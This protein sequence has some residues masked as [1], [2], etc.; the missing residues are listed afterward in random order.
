MTSARDIRREAD[1]SRLRRDAARGTGSTR[2]SPPS[3][4]RAQRGGARVARWPGVAG[5]SVAVVVRPDERVSRSSRVPRG[6]AIASSLG[7]TRSSSGGTP[8]RSGPG[9]SDRRTR[10]AAPSC[11][12]ASAASV[13]RAG[14]APRSRSRCAVRRLRAGDGLATGVRRR[15]SRRLLRRS[16]SCRSPR[17]SSPPT[18]SART[19]PRATSRSARR[20]AR[21]SCSLATLPYD[22]D[23]AHER[24]SS[25]SRSRSV[26][27]IVVG[28][29]LR[30]RAAL[31]RALREKAALLERRGE[32]AAGRAVADERTRIAGEL[33]DVV[34]HALSAMTV[35]A[36]G[37]RRLALTRPELAREAF[38]AIES[39][40]REALDELRR[41]LG[42]LRREDAELDARARSRRCATCARSLAAHDRAPGLPVTL[43]VEGEERELPA[44]IDVTAYRVVQDALAA[45]LELGG[46][47]R[48][49]VRLRFCAARGRDRRPRRRPVGD[50]AA[51]DGHPRA[52]R[53]PRRPLRRARARRPAAT[54]S[55]R[56][57]RSTAARCR[58][59]TR[60]APCELAERGDR[61]LRRVGAA[62]RA[63]PAAA[64]R[65]DRAARAAR[66]R[67]STGSSR[68]SSP[69]PALV[70]VLLSP[71]LAG[72]WSPTSR[73]RSATPSRSRWR[74][75]A[76]L[77]RARRD[78][79]GDLDDGPHADAG[80]GPLRAVR[81]R[82]HGR[83]TRAP[84]TATG[85][86]RTPGSC[87]SPPRCPRSSPRWTT[88]RRRLRLP[89]ADRDRRVARRAHRARA[90]A[91]RGRA[92]RDRRAAR[93]GAARTRGALAAVDERRRIAREM[94]D[95]VAHSM[96][97]MV[98][99]A[100]GAR[101][102]LDRDPGRALEAADADRAHRPRGAGRDAPP[103]R[104]ARRHRPAGARSRRSRRSREI[105]ELV[106]R[107][108]AAGPADR[109]RG[110]RRRAAPLPAGLDLAAYRIVQEAL[111]NALKHA[112]HARTD[113]DRRLGRGRRSRSRSATTAR[114]TA[115]RRHRP[116]PR[117]RRACASACGS[118]AA[119]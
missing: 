82:A 55:A 8:C 87:S 105:G 114:G 25:R 81:R 85:G 44:G 109:A 49:E 23:V 84:P 31:N 48:A 43:R 37:A 83:A 56:R 106:A 28:R 94:H 39:A 40:G 113:C 76:P 92:A 1:T 27:P 53:P 47:G 29:L 116:R 96:S 70:E 101:R 66:R 102:I 14:R 4:G 99:Q 110:P 12:R 103:A 98:V 73:S 68:P 2:R 112:G 50:R 51:A 22:E 63:A 58:A 62:S 93:G 108:R 65:A 117:P 71:E 86:R 61:A 52:R 32:D 88:G 45:A 3:N 38:G 115:A 30:S 119:S 10:P 78:R 34:A 90:H 21:R 7:M 104:R 95:L 33:H 36:T 18:G 15:C 91:A 46:A 111:T 35:Q 89:A 59:K 41:L 57:C 24:R 79:C 97:V 75:R 6:R 19:R 69:S 64:T 13:R 72:P 74:R 60:R 80:R 67:P 54:S 26:A 16:C 107:A 5:R 100:G 9:P 77:A 118:T 17:R 42:V 20:R 11:A